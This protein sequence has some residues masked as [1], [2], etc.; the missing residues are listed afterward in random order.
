MRARFFF[1]AIAGFWLVMNFLLWRSQ[2]AA[3]SALGSEVPPEI[4]WD[5]ILTAPDN[6][7]LDIFDHGR[8]IG[9]CHWVASVGAAG[10]AF[11]QTL[12]EDYEPTGLLPQP[13]SY[14][15]MIDGGSEFYTTNHIRFEAQLRLSTNE[16]W[17]DFHLTAK[18]RPLPLSWEVHAI[19]A[20]QRVSVKVDDDGT[21]WQN[22]FK[23]AD[24]AH[25]QA[26][27]E[28]WGGVGGLGLIGSALP[29]TSGAAMQ[30]NLGLH[31]V[32]HE[33]WM[34]F[35]HARVKVYRLETQFLG[36]HLYISTSRVGEILLVEAPNQ[37]I[38]RNEAFSH[39]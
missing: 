33:D 20:A 35:G 32:A 2:S 36:Q 19:A 13:S 27:L 34:Q 25:P 30:A 17:Q 4:V 21:L 15:L 12:S 5:K 22:S 6:S 37:L 26:L 9:Y 8:K 1:I 10:Q 28:S 23:F 7:S 16:S 18:I 29:L 14:S 11:N 24:I 39:L 3:H 38:L 31:W